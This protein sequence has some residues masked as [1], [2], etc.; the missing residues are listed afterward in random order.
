MLVDMISI[1]F[2][3]NSETRPT[4]PAESQL[5]SLAAPRSL[6]MP[7]KELPEAQGA[8][9]GVAEHGGKESDQHL[10][11]KEEWSDEHWTPFG[12]QS[13]AHLLESMCESPA[14]EGTE[15]RPDSSEEVWLAKAQ[16]EREQWWRRRRGHVGVS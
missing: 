2:H 7:P 13:L 6:P 4:Q 3:R 14:T 11:W 8:T 9:I 16:A 5:E 12:I 15:M 1:A 10:I